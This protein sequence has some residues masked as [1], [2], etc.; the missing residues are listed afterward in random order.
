MLKRSKKATLTIRSNFSLGESKT[1]IIIETVRSCLYEMSRV[2]EIELSVVPGLVLEKI[3]RD[4][5]KSAP[6]LHTLC[7]EL[8]FG[9]TFSIDEDFLYDTERLQHVELIDCEISWDSQLLTGLT[10]LSL[11]NSLKA[12]TSIIQ[13]LDALRRM[14]A[15]SHLHLHDSIP[16]DSEGSSTYAVVNLPYLRELNISSGVG[17]LTPFLR[18]IS[19]PHS[20]ILGLICKGN[21][22]PETVFSEFLSVLATRF[23]SS[24]VIRSLKV[25]FPI[26]II[27]PCYPDGLEFYLWSNAPNQ[28]C[29]PILPTS[30]SQLHLVLTWYSPHWAQHHDYMNALTC[31]FD[32]MCLSFLTQLQISIRDEIDSQ[33]WVETFGKLP[34]LERVCVQGLEP[35]AFLE[36]LAYKTKAAEKSKKAYCR[37]VSFPKLRY[38]HMV[39]TSYQSISVD[40]LLDCLMERYERNVEVQVL[41]LENCYNISSDEV[42]R[43]KEVVIDVI[44]DGNINKFW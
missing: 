28:D 43:L 5:P 31:A 14:P 39:G 21:H 19:F 35:Y 9:T 23:L 27:E 12:N 16:D 2:E 44:W 10:R 7:L 42:D 30:L 6:Q 15:L 25:G 3:F 29:F 17:A 41:H 22:S 20:T 4:L 36:A 13:V 18:H 1:T 34:I 24:L 38:I 8:L 32:A 33:T 37:N 26:D 40:T 11:E